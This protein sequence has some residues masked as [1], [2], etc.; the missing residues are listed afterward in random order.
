VPGNR[1]AAIDSMLPN[2]DELSTSR[3]ECSVPAYGGASFGSSPRSETTPSCRCVPRQ[4][5]K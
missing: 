5:R 2:S 1:T 4:N 3:M